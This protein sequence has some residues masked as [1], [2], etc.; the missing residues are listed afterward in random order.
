MC[1]H[2]GLV[3]LA[4]LLAATAVEA[5]EPAP[6]T[7]GAGFY[8]RSD[9]LA[10]VGRTRGALHRGRVDMGMR[11]LNRTRHL[12]VDVGVGI[13]GG[14]QRRL[15]DP[16]DRVVDFGLSLDVR[17]YLNPGHRLQVF[18]LGGVAL[19][20][21]GGSEHDPEE[22]VPA[23]AEDCPSDAMF[24]ADVSGGVGLE[25]RL[26]R[27]AALSGTFRVLRRTHLLGDLVFVEGGENPPGG[28]TDHLLGVAIGVDLVGYFDATPGS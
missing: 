10:G 8:L 9:Y 18:G 14:T 12:G 21:L 19:G 22:A 20:V 2:R 6:T 5:Q 15:L 16:S 7:A 3:V 25:L 4:L 11:F 1:A 27:N 28:T 24:F 23:S 17:G 13:G 26:S